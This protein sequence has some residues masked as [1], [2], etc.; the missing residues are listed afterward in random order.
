M[1]ALKLLSEQARAAIEAEFSKYPDKRS[2]L[3]PALWIA[4]D[5]VGY[6]PEAA[7]LE[8]AAI[9]DISPVQV[10]EVATFYTM[11]NLSPVGR[12]HIQF[13]KT[14]SCVLV[15]AGPLI[16]H[17]KK[18]L[19]IEVGEVTP[20]GLFSLKLVECLAACGSGPAMQINAD[21][22]EYLTLGKIDQILDDL[23]NKGQSPLASG[24]YR[25]PLEVVS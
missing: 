4:Q 9:L 14:L 11:Y 2:V 5:E 6:L 13:C 25:I 17:L 23:K 10:Y 18:R 15:G 21:Y 16:E 8:V 22:Y 19:Q 1:G 7:L 12:Y 20:D 3:L 24:P